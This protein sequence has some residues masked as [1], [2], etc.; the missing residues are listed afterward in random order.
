LIGWMT[1]SVPDGEAISNMEA[2]LDAYRSIPDYSG[3]AQVLGNLGMA[4]LRQGKL[5]RA[6]KLF[7]DALETIQAKGVRAI[8][9]TSVYNGLAQAYLYAAEKELYPNERSGWLREAH[10]ACA[11]A[12]RHGK[13]DLGGLAEAQRLQGNCEWLRGNQA[14][15]R[16]WWKRSIETA[17]RQA[18]PYETALTY[19]E[20]GE[21]MHWREYLSQAELSLQ[22]LGALYDLERVQK[23][24][25][26]LQA[27][28]S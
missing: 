4:Y 9:A 21:H 8:H 20:L 24:Q 19:I 2:A 1:A 3:S 7:D 25:D 5:K 22:K 18:Q 13:V 27:G 12:L 15:A 28:R 26:D 10:Q 14:V 17:R 11:Q 16:A 23:L 6:I